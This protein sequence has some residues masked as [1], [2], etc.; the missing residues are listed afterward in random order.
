MFDADAIRERVFA[1]YVRLCRLP[2][3]KEWAWHEI[4][5]MD[6]EDLFKGIKDHVLKEMKK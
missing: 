2:A 6:K 1:D 5:R 3:W 4:K